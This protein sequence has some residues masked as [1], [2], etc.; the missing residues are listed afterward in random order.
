MSAP[1]SQIEVF[2]AS[3]AVS[4]S[5][6]S[7]TPL[8]ILEHCPDKDAEVE[9]VELEFE[10]TD[11]EEHEKR[12][13][14][15]ESSNSLTMS[16]TNNQDDENSEESSTSKPPR[17]KKP[18]T[19]PAKTA[20]PSPT[21]PLP[22]TDIQTF[23]ALIPVGS[24]FAS[25][26]QSNLKA[27][28]Q[29][30]QSPI[31]STFLSNSKSNLKN[32]PP[33]ARLLPIGSNV[34]YGSKSSKSKGRKLVYIDVPWTIE[35]L[36]EGKG[37]LH[38]KE[39]DDSFSITDF[40]YK[41]PD[42]Y[43]K[44]TNNSRCMEDYFIATKLWMKI[45]NARYFLSI[46]RRKF[47]PHSLSKYID[48]WNMLVTQPTISE[49]HPNPTQYISTVNRED[50]DYLPTSQKMVDHI[51]CVSPILQ[52]L[53]FAYPHLC[54]HLIPEQKKVYSILKQ[55]KDNHVLWILQYA[56][57]RDL[58]LLSLHTIED[59]STTETMRIYFTLLSQFDF[60]F[61]SC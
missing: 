21:K 2:V 54:K 38:K 57:T 20:V 31:G 18:K 59:V 25:L 28:P 45:L 8:V 24:S 4:L 27:P 48:Q 33:Q 41:A 19:S 58:G 5:Q 52:I 46:K 26:S 47:I 9:S 50:A 29:A 42:A 37:I 11:F 55:I 12:S 16:D 49:S 17:P 34:A 13:R 6:P 60:P 7:C 51:F 36:K 44:L 61:F 40:P 32:P 35:C 3:L 22:R 15:S 14:R 10:D 30:P 39:I 23:G 53:C 43:P 56:K 1:D